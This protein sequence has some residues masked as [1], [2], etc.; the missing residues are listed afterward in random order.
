MATWWATI[1]SP[2]KRS[3]SMCYTK[4]K[5]R[6]ENHTWDLVQIT[7]PGVSLT[8]VDQ[9]CLADLRVCLASGM[10]SL[11]WCC[12]SLREFLGITRSL[13]WSLVGVAGICAAL[14]V[15]GMVL[16]C[17]SA[18]WGMLCRRL[19]RRGLSSAWTLALAIFW[20]CRV[21]SHSTVEAERFLLA[22]KGKLW[23]H[24]ENLSYHK[25][26]VHN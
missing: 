21:T 12:F 14:W 6:L 26:K 5:P 20:G 2:A 10:S 23:K 4:N 11:D 24:G 18:L 19:D 3:T 17:R 22:G 16:M 13:D 25:G 9:C 1:K 15:L 8:S 7:F